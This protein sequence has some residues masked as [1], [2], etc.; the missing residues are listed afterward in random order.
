MRRYKPSKNYQHNRVIVR[1]YSLSPVQYY[2]EDEIN[3]EQFTNHLIDCSAEEWL[4]LFKTCHPH[5][6]KHNPQTPTQVYVESGTANIP[7]MM[8]DTFFATYQPNVYY[9]KNSSFKD[10]STYLIKEHYPNETEYSKVKRWLGN[11][12]PTL[13]EGTTLLQLEFIFQNPNA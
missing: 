10:F 8:N 12:Y 13:T 7:L 4:A 1:H 2:M 3:I 5:H 11:T 9:A 6:F